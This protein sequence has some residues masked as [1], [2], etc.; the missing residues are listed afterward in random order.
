M[1]LFTAFDGEWSLEVSTKPENSRLVRRGSLEEV[2][3][4]HPDVVAK[5]HAAALD[6]IERRG[7]DAALMAWLRSGGESEFP[8]N[9]NYWDGYPGPAG[10]RPYF[11]KLYTGD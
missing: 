6:E 3:N 4:E 2:Q 7:T 11:G 9:P 1:N 10:F 5:L 8:E